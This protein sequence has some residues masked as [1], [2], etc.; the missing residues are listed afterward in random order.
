[1]STSD[2]PRVRYAFLDRLT[3]GLV[4]PTVTHV[5][6]D[7][8]PRGRSVVAL[9][10]A[11]LAGR[12]PESVDLSW[13]DPEL[14]A[15]LL[16][17]I[18]GSGVA[19][20][21]ADDPRLTDEVVR[22][23][24]DAIHES[25]RL[26]ERAIVAL[27]IHVTDGGS[28]CSR[29]GGQMD[30]EGWRK[31]RAAALRL[32]R[33]LAID[34]LATGA[35]RRWGD[36]VAI[37]RELLGCLVGLRRAAGLPPGVER[38]LLRSLP[39][40]DLLQLRSLLAS[41]EPLSDLLRRLGRLRDDDDATGQPVLRQ[42]A[43]AVARSRSDRETVVLPAAGVEIR[44]VERGGDLAR[45]LPSEAAMLAHPTLARLFRARLVERALLAYHA[46]GALS[47]RI[48]ARQEIDDED[49]DREQPVAR[50]PIV[51]VL[52][53]SGSMRGMPE[54]LAKALVMQML[55]V[56]FME[57]RRCYAYS[58]SGPDQVIEHELSL[59]GEGLA[60]LLD[61]LSY[62]FHGGTVPDA[63]LQRAV[64]RLDQAE[65]HAADLVVASDGE[66]HVEPET[67]SALDALR[68]RRDVRVHGIT[69]GTT[70]GFDELR[71]D[72]L[73]VLEDWIHALRA[74]TG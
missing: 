1:M 27:Q 43:R 45:M 10:E 70:Y 13:P 44:G 15:A 59:E 65:W 8:V 21:C 63:A 73:H 71:C 16:A 34:L 32:G 51:I 24:L 39:L 9:R 49:V 35:T 57:K 67:R 33:D 19:E 28:C 60:R 46:T 56:C 61:F 74:R 54:E 72:A 48:R 22:Y 29:G 18:R 55:G 38:G 7:L 26:E 58:F 36:R 5:H 14:R 47:E 3:E 2:L 11:L 52:D 66:F 25:H 62:S 50:G 31:H 42:V 6:G 4:R 17:G 23:A 40:L 12:V 30:P 68:A 69:V 20:F 64:R 37:W 53:T 41:L